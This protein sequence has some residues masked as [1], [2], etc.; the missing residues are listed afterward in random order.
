ML[1]EYIN[2]KFV[3]HLFFCVAPNNCVHKSSSAYRYIQTSK[4]TKEQWAKFWLSE[5]AHRENADSSEQ[6]PIY[7]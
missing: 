2:S 5:I 7:V 4:R 6:N 1:N 3:G